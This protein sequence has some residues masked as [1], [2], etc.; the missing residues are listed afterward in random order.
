MPS[1]REFRSP[2]SLVVLALLREHPMHVYGLHRVIRERGQDRLVNVEHRNSVRQTVERLQ[3]AACVEVDEMQSG[4]G[5]VRTVYRITT[6]GRDLLDE[7]LREAVSTPR[8]EYPVFPV[9]ASLLAFYSPPEVAELLA[10]RRAVLVD[11]RAELELSLKESPGLPGI[12]VVESELQVGLID[13]E[14][15]WIDGVTARISSGDL[16]WDTAA[17]IEGSPMIDLLDEQAE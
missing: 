11:Q 4:E 15:A 10:Q 3:R 13:A 17:L 8:R 6:T 5:P 1:R 7:I 16:E 9:A 12:L 2:L 14:L